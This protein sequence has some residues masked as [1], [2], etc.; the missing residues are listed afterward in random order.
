VI[1]EMQINKSAV[2][3]VVTIIVAVFACIASIRS[4]S[5]SNEALKTAKA[6]FIAEKRPYLQISAAKFSKS[7]KYLE[8]EKTRDGKAKLRFLFKIENIG[9]VAATDIRAQVLPINGKEGPIPTKL[10]GR[11]PNPLEIG[12]AQHVFKEHG[13]HISPKRPGDTEKNVDGLRKNPVE[14]WDS[15]RYRSEIDSTVEYEAKIGFLIYADRTVLL[16]RE[17]KRLPGSMVVPRP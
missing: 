4:C 10:E 2:L 16:L 9:N 5:V 13:Y 17:T 14:I 15:I 12:P 7:N 1:V 8:I 3:N 6:Q 11:M